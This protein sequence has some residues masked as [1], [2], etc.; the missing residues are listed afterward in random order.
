MSN[1][2]NVPHKVFGGLSK[3]YGMGCMSN[4]DHR[5]DNI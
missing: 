3:K 2:G 4:L 1:N 5:K